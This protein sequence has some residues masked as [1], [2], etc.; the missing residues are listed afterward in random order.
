MK[1]NICS[2]ETL[3]FLFFFLY[4]L[5]VTF[6]EDARIWFARNWKLVRGEFIITVSGQK[7]IGLDRCHYKICSRE[8]F[9]SFEKGKK[10][11]QA[12]TYLLC[13]S[14]LFLGC[15]KHK[16]SSTNLHAFNGCWTWS[17]L[18][19]RDYSCFMIRLFLCVYFVC[20]LKR[21]RSGMLTLEHTLALDLM[22][23]YLGSSSI[24]TSCTCT[25]S[26]I[27]SLLVAS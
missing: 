9:S 23:Y 12:V 8:L 24:V 5:S 4:E 21:V 1:I 19:L 20:V 22:N 15:A 3:W 14:V 18:W 11:C 10:P 16:A 26:R 6:C 2:K 27:C 7:M 17:H 25:V 13:V